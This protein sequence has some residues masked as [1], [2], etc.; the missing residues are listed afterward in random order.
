MTVLMKAAVRDASTVVCLATYSVVNWVAL[1]Y[2]E[3][4]TVNDVRRG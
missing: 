2:I 1:K 3:C 4:I